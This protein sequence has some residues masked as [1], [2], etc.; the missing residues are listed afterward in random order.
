MTMQHRPEPPDRPR[1]FQCGADIT[2]GAP[3]C[4]ACGASQDIRPRPTYEAADRRT[5]PRWVPVAVV[6]GA[7]AALGGGALLSVALLGGDNVTGASSP[8]PSASASA[9]TSASPSASASA[10]TGTEPSPPSPTEAAPPAP[11]PSPTPP[12]A[13]IIPNLAIA[14]VVEAVNLRSGRSDG[15]TLLRELAVGQRL[16]VIG[17]P[18]EADG[19]RWYRVAAFHQPLCQP[20]CEMIGFVATPIAQGDVWVE[21]AD[22]NCPTSP[23]SGTAI[24]ELHAYEALSCYGN[25]NI[26]ITGTVEHACCPADHQHVYGVDW[27]QEPVPAWLVGAFGIGFHPHPAADLDIPGNGAAVRVS[28]HFEDPAATQCRT[29]FRPDIPIAAQGLPDQ[30]LV[31]LNCRATFVWTDYEIGVVR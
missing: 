19:L 6:A 5:T 18:T 23:I 11:T 12:T 24:A 21:E 31:V 30:A 25:N 22:V 16:F 1:C 17:A 29:S 4:A 10:S 15:S 3:F 14:Q 8:S 13:A 20:E 2:P 28:G 7:L 26:S 9:S 27:L